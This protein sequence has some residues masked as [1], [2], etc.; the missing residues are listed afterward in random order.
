MNKYLTAPRA[1]KD[2]PKGIPYIIGNEAAERFSFYGM[3]GILVV[4][5]TKYLHILTDNPNLAAMNKAAAIEQYHNFTSWVYLTPILGALLAD[6]LLGKYR[7]IISLS[8]VY[9]LGH[10]TL[11]F[12]GSGGLTPE[13]W[14]MTGLALISLGSGG[15]KP[16]V[17]A[18]VGDQFG[19]S[20][21]TWLTKVFGWFYISINVGAFI[22]TILTPWLLEWYGPHLAF[23]IPGI[24]MAIA[25]YV[26]WLGRKKFIH[27]Q[28]KGMGFIRE[29]FSREGLK[30][31]AK[32]AIIFSFVAVFWALFDQTGSSWVLQAEDLNRNWLGVHWLPSQIQAINPIMIVIMV[33]IFAFG[34]YPVLD[35]VF[36]LTPLRKVSI[37][38]FV[39]V[40]GFAMV[41]VVQQWVDQGQQPSIG[42]QIFAYAILTSSEVMVSITCLE[43]AYTQA[44]RSMKSVIMALFLMSVSLGN[45]FTAGVNSFI[46][47]PNQLVAATSLNMT[48]QAKDKNG[49]K[50]LSTQEDILK[51]T[52]QTKD[53]NG[54]SIQYITNQE[55]SYTLILAGKDGTFG[56]TTDIRLKFSKGG[57]QIAV[58]T[59]EK[60]N[61][62]TAF[63]KI[64]SYFD[65]NKNTLP[66]TQA[67][68]D[69]IKSIIDNWGSPL[70]YRLVNRN[71][72]RITSLGADKN[73]MTENDIVL[74]STISRPSKDESAKKKPYSW[75]ENRIIELKGDEGKREV[76][77][78][79]G[80]IKEIE[81]DTA[82]MVGGQ[83]NLEGSDYFWFFTWLML[84][85][86][87]VFVFVALMY[88]PKTFL[89][90]ED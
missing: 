79:R 13:A 17:S 64:K 84:G 3:K 23:G 65:S 69:L 42:W 9:C 25:T 74:I 90:E 18:H 22:S 30:T 5:M 78:S 10:L 72:F 46:Q 47:V 55:G 35:K 44:P 21:A 12:M 53:I 16:C 14:M 48:I 4:F 70:Q 28:P 32:L 76:V 59:A 37:G 27:I 33:P 71:M 77:K 89:H 81:F 15:I 49:K 26:F 63:V 86:A 43:F 82:I 20:N 41:S 57:K 50:L 1:S 66:K 61:L 8:L 85:T 54:N 24:L 36:P 52:S 11:A 39:M 40:I 31:M 7:T 87:L 88:E 62:N 83:T 58:K 6:T 67:G 60:T 73:Y 45:F 34:I 29:T 19:E 75:R 68:T 80:G 51:L 56:T 2:I 38:L